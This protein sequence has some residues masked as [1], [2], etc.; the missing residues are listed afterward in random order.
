[1]TA[2]QSSFE[3]RTVLVTGAAGGLGRAL[4]LAFAEA[5]ARI[6]ALDRDAA[7]LEGL[8]AELESLGRDCLAL[9][10]DVTDATACEQAVAAGVA[11]FGRLD[12]LVNNA[13]MSHRSG[14]AHTGLDVIRRVMEVNFFGAVNCTRAALPALVAA[15]GLVIAISSVAG[16][17]PLIARTGYAASKH[18]MHG[19]FDSLRSELEPQGVGVMIVCPSF[20]ATRIDVNALG[21][22]GAPVR[23]AQVTVGE[24]LAPDDVADTIF[25]GA[26]RNRRLLLAGR[27]AKQA[28]WLSR[29][30]PRLY[31]RL[32]SSRMRAE[33]DGR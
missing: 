24:P 17:T 7:G 31:D 32:M 28:W 16:Y 25:E 22:D 33:L 29:L 14:F 26:S 5:G 23:H 13:G 3:G 15:R 9:P 18:A 19:F 2:G 8:R 1:M 11:R 6:V 10:C 27:T 20:I 21:G 12:V 4:A 30:A